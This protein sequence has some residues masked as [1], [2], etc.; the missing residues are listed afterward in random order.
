VDVVKSLKFVQ[1][2]ILIDDENPFGSA[3]TLLDTFLD[4]LESRNATFFPTPVDKSKAVSV[5][6]LSSGTTGLPK[7]VQLSQDNIIVVS[8]FCKNTA[9]KL[10]GLNDDP[11][12]L[13]L[14]PWFHAFGLTSLAGVI[15]STIG[16][17][18][19][20]PKFEEGLFLG[21]IENYR[22]SVMTIVPPLMVFLAKHPLVDE[23]DLSSLRVLICGAAPLSKELEQAV[24]DRL[25]NPLLK[26][27]QGY[28]MSELS[29]STF[30]QMTKFKP[31]SVGE[32]VEGS[33]AKI[34]DEDG[35][36][37]GPNQR[38]ELCMKG[39]QLMLGYIGDEK[40][41]RDTIDK[42]G[43]LHTGD[44]A[45]YDDDKQFFVVDRLKELIKWKGFQ[46]PPA[47][48]GG[49]LLTHPKIKDAAVIGIPDERAGELPL[50][51]VVKADDDLTE[52]EVI[53]FVASRVSPPKRLHGGVRFI[54]EIP[55][56]LAGKILRR[57]LR[58]MFQ[59][60]NIKSKL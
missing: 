20:L 36:S 50:A 2:L 60:S 42:E 22:C 39:N 46:V 55:K 35:K 16:R 25:K 47:E 52:E 43:W 27:H 37:L 10:S 57:E 7:G 41:T 21:C 31:G 40:A 28:G 54:D 3:V 8:R 6:L 38:G 9:S 44:V 12:G 1:K 34:I 33:M 19:L 26:I 11:T 4:S 15:M 49:I 53:Q 14:I 24:L 5:I 51:F 32:V 59:Q 23:F 18:V 56:N 29:L 45:Y 13:G 17:I 30:L 48:I 58:E